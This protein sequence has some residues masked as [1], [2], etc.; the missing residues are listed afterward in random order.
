MNTEELYNECH[1]RFNIVDGQLIYKVKPSERLNVGHIAG[2][3]DKTT[4]YLRT[5]VGTKKYYVHRL[6]FLMSTHYLPKGIDHIDGDKTNNLMENLRD[7]TQSQNCRNKKKRSGC[8]SKYRGVAFAK[9]RNKWLASINLK[10]LVCC[11]T[12]LVTNSM[13]CSLRC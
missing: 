1:R 9:E 3:K 2:S 13:I 11:F 4:G 6:I 10:A 5:R 8:T 12:W 7:I